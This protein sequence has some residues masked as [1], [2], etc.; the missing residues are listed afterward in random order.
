MA[1]IRWTSEAEKWLK[2]IYDYIAQNNLKAAKNEVYMIK[3]NCCEIFRKS[4]IERFL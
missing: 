3:C 2:D 4:G 1:E